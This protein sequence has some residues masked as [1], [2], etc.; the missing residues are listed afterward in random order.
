LRNILIINTIFH[1]Y[2]SSFRQN[3]AVFTNP[4]F[5]AKCYVLDVHNA[6]PSRL[7][8]VQAKAALALATGASISSTAR[9]LGTHRATI[10]RWMSK[11]SFQFALEKAQADHLDKFTEQLK[12]VKMERK[13]A[14][15]R[16]IVQQSATP[17]TVLP[18]KPKPGRNEPCPCRSGKKYK[19]CCGGVHSK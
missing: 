1:F 13:V 3:F 7:S 4:F 12:H 18:N 16:N 19:K 14:T 6:T 11:D 9:L 10:H 15:E 17:Q 2:A 8:P 5:P